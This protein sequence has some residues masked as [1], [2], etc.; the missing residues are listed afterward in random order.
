[1]ASNRRDFAIGKEIW[2]KQSYA[3]IRIFTGSTEI[4]VSAHAQQNTAKNC[5][6]YCYMGTI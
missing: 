3:E 6:K 2:V 5:H 1:M 4:A